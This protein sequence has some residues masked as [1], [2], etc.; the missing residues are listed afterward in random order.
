M[1]RDAVGASPYQAF[2]SRDVG[3]NL[4]QPGFSFRRSGSTLFFFGGGEK[5]AFAVADA[6]EYGLNPVIIALR[7]GIELV[8]VAAGTV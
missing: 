3:V 6:L 1:S 7:D 8:I 5:A 2:D 4:I